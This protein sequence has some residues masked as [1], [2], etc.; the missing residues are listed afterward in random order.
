MVEYAAA[1]KCDSRRISL[2]VLDLVADAVLYG[3]LRGVVYNGG[4]ARRRTRWN[5]TL[6]Y[7]KK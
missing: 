1:L 4:Q 3:Q 6:Y 2:Q 7:I 5:V